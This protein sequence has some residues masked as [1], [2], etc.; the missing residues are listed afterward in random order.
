VYRAALGAGRG[1]KKR[2]P[3]PRVGPR[4]G[5]RG[6]GW[7]RGPQS[8]GS[9]ARPRP[10][11]DRRGHRRRP[12]PAPGRPR[13]RWPAPEARPGAR[14]L[15]KGR[16]GPR[17]AARAAKGRDPAKANRPA[18]AREDPGG[19]NAAPTPGARGK[20]C[21]KCHSQGP[22]GATKKKLERFDIERPIPMT[23]P[24]GAAPNSVRRWARRLGISERN[25]GR[26]PFGK[27]RGGDRGT[28][29]RRSRAWTDAARA[30]NKR[31]PPTQTQAG[32]LPTPA[33]SPGGCFGI[34][35]SVV[36]VRNRASLFV[37]GDAPGFRAGSRLR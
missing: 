18:V 6:S 10:T 1:A 21:A 25:P 34:F 28:R 2:L 13:P 30:A 26:C 9:T 3:A 27:A 22:R 35:D 31:P 19:D 15:Q 23:G 7:R 24:P 14:G 16:P 11:A 32:R 8:T 12:R 37:Q 4:P 17:K 33:R 20:Y 36:W 29:S 5:G